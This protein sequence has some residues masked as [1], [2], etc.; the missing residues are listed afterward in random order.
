M[1]LELQSI[2]LLLLSSVF[3]QVAFFFRCKFLTMIEV[4]KS[5]SGDRVGKFVNLIM[6]LTAKVYG[7]LPENV[8]LLQLCQYS[9]CQFIV[10]TDSFLHSY[11]R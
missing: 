11:L 6:I 1:Q 10:D 5:F 8:L 2:R 3:A 9:W 4:D 7:I